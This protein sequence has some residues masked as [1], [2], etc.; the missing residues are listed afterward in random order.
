MATQVRLPPPRLVRGG[1]NPASQR[2]RFLFDLNMKA[3]SPAGTETTVAATIYGEDVGCGDFVALLNVTWELPSY[4]W[5]SCDALLPSHELIR[6]KVIPSEAGQPLKVFAVCLPFIYART[7]RGEMKTIDLRRVQIVRLNC[8]SAKL[9]WNEL[10][11]G[12]KRN[13]L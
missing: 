13:D 7:A 8:A 1:V 5:N 6:L 3:E 10:K 11:H 4:L 2:R 9:V 12:P